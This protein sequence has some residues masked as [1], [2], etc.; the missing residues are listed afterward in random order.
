M[1]VFFRVILVCVS[2]FFFYYVSRKLKKEQM[3]KNDTIFWILFSCLLIVVSVFPK[4]LDMAAQF[5]GIYSTENTVF[6]VIIFA[7]LLRLFLLTIKVS[8]LESQIAGLAA[9]LVV[10]HRLDEEKKT[11]DQER[12]AAATEEA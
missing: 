7:L 2:C 12:P 11:E 9:E 3:D 10:R 4:L 5:L 1:S 8:R 6:L